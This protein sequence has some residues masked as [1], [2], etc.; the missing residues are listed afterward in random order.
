MRQQNRV[1]KL[2]SRNGGGAVSSVC[3]I[4]NIFDPSECGP[5][6]CGAHYVSWFGHESLSG[7]TFIRE[8]GEAEA[9]FLGRA[10]VRRPHE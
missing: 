4:R 10:G 3:I 5:V 6:D 2:E 1:S 8:P 7:Q 9:L